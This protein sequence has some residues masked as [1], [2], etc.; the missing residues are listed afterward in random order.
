MISFLILIASGCTP[1]QR[2]HQGRTSPQ[3]HKRTS[4]KHK[5]AD[6]PTTFKTNSSFEGE[7]SFY[8]PGFHGNL[9]AN[10][11]IYN[12]NDFTCAHPSLP[13]NTLLRVTYLKTGK[14]VEVRVNDRGPY[15]KKRI[16]D[17]SVAAA[18]EIG[19]Y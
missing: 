13:F 18:K 8:G 3:S 9:T 4:A 16:I 14:S 15:K 6:Q 19:M 5:N 12:Q 7:A 1:S 11:E 10:G 17:L 2:Y